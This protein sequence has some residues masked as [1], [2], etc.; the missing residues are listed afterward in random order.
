MDFSVHRY[1]VINGMKAFLAIDIWRKLSSASGMT[2]LDA[3][4]EETDLRATSSSIDWPRS[5]S[6]HYEQC[7]NLN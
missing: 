3:L 6:E 2:F 1:F 5:G 7:S 4:R